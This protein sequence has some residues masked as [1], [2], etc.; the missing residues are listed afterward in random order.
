MSDHC[1]NCSHPLK[2][3]FF[4]SSCKKIQPLRVMNPY[5]RLG[6]NPDPVLSEEVLR[7]V[8]IDLHFQFHPDRFLMK[9]DR[10]KKYALEHAEAI[11]AA[12]SLLKTPLKRF[13]LL[14]PSGADPVDP[15]EEATLLEEVIRWNQEIASGNQEERQAL[16]KILFEQQEA[17]QA[18][19]IKYFK[20]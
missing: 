12:F 3:D 16:E 4:C 19:F 8:Y 5:E 20:E 10:E 15:L 1:W 14:L 6:L 13:E 18:E 11:N 9:S 17:L 2:S 7:K